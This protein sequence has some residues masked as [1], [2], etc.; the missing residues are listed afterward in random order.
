MIRALTEADIP[1]AQRLREQAGWNQSDDDW[2]RLLRWEPDGCWVDERDGTVVGTT[3]VITYGQRIAWI[4]MVL[5]DVEHRRQGIGGALLAHALAHLDRLGVQTI[6]LDSTPAAQPIYARLG[7]VD[8]YGLERRRGPVPPA[9]SLPTCSG[10][11]AIRPLEPVDLPSVMAYDGRLFGTERPHV[12]GALY[13][14]HPG[15][16]FLAERGGEVV[17]YVLTRPGARAWHVGPL[18]AEDHA[19]AERLVRTALLPH[20]GQDCVLD[21]VTPNRGAVALAETLGLAPVRP[22]IRMA[23]GE[24]PP[25]IDA[26]CLYTSAGPELG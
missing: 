21:I 1:A 16:S 12:L 11:A 26:V 13:D 7:F 4:G 8:A 5:V 24:P 20:E 2:R 25:A 14:G 17:G 3:A 19:T 22:F 10:Q 23:R 6:A 9:R 18:A 15:G